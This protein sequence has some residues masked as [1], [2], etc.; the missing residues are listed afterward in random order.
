[1]GNR[2][3]KSVMNQQ[4]IKRELRMFYWNL[5]QKQEMVID[6]DKIK[7][8]TGHLRT[9]SEAE[10]T[11]LELE[12]TMSGVSQCLKSI[13]NNVAPGSGGFSGAFYKVFVLLP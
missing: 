2:N 6:W 8:M 10:K 7:K 13:P 1:M 3:E 11:K 4:Q 9:I 5:Y 12:I